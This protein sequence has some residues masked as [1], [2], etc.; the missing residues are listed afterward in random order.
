MREKTG[1][2]VIFLDVDG[3][4]N[5][6]ECDH[7][8]KE[9]DEGSEDFLYHES[10]PVPLLRRSLDNLRCVLQ[11]T[12]AKIVISSSWRL[13]P[14]RLELLT[15]ILEGLSCSKDPVVIGLTP[16]LSDSWSG[17]GEEVRLWLE[18]NKNCSRFVVAKCSTYEF[19]SVESFDEENLEETLRRKLYIE[20]SSKLPFRIAY[21]HDE[22][23]VIS[24]L[25]CEENYV[26]SK[27]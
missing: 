6:E 3:V 26:K 21:N 24:T 1:M 11:Q 14:E 18:R 20:Y 25:N 27:E 5:S 22:F 16:D 17:R 2:N 4:L 12:E 9:G 15:R 19:P 13:F 7:A 10:T 8:P 23:T